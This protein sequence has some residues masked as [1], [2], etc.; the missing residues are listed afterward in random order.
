MEIG[1]GGSKNIEGLDGLKK[2][3]HR[4][5]E[6]CYCLVTNQLKRK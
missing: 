2:L 5:I 1:L 4:Q 6:G 3:G